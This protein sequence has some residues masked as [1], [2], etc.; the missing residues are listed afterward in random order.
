MATNLFFKSVALSIFV[1]LLPSSIQKPLNTTT[2]PTSSSIG[3]CQ[4][5]LK[6]GYCMGYFPRWFYNHKTKKCQQFI[7]GGC[8]GNSNN[9][10][11]K[12]ACHLT[13]HA[14]KQQGLKVHVPPISTFK[15][16]VK[17]FSKERRTKIDLKP[18]NSVP[19]LLPPPQN[20]TI[21]AAQPC[22]IEKTKA[23]DSNQSGIFVP[24]C[25]FQGNY[26]T[27]Q[28]WKPLGLK[29]SCWCVDKNGRKTGE[30]QWGKS[31]HKTSLKVTFG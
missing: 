26:E 1:V 30:V 16:T 3:V 15:S 10:L 29:E 19:L 5:P 25:D 2:K 13:C 4:L 6:P 31:C 21:K 17:I 8:N 20:Q 22:E 11:S 12:A 18:K 14:G 23:M 9:F 24:K 27:V 28:C 7:Y